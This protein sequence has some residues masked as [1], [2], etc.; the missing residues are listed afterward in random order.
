[1]QEF[2]PK[3]KNKVLTKEFVG[4]YAYVLILAVLLI[5]GISYGYTFFIQ[6]KKITSGSITTA[7]LTIN[8]TDRTINA[9]NL[10]V[11][12]DDGEGLVEFSKSVTIT[13]QTAIDGR[14]K[15]TLSRTSGLNLTDLRYALI[16]NGAIQ[17]IDDVPSDGV[18]LESAI[19]G[20]EVINVEVRLWP[21]STYSGSAT[22]FVGELT[23]EIKYLGPVAAD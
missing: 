5:G 7:A 13:N 6:N 17:I 8:F 2:E 21:K 1:M 19:M 14:V 3:R 23:P 9:T 22:T 16:V 4:K 18:I 12:T 10:S 20:S 11:P 15:L